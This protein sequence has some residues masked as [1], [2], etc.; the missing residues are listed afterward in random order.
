[1]VVNLLS[2][3]CNLR[4]VEKVLDAFQEVLAALIYKTGDVFV[5]DGTNQAKGLSE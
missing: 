4:V 5:D 2:Q 1:V 3:P